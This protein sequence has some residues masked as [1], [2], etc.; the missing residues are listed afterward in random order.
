MKGLSVS[1]FISTRGGFCLCRVGLFQYTHIPTRQ[2]IPSFSLYNKIVNRRCMV[3]FEHLLFL[4]YLCRFCNF[5]LKSWE[6]KKL[7]VDR[8]LALESPIVALNRLAEV[9]WYIVTE[10][11]N[12]SAIRRVATYKRSMCLFFP[13]CTTVLNHFDAAN[14][15]GW[16]GLGCTS[17]CRDFPH[18]SLGLSW[19]GEFRK[20]IIIHGLLLILIVFL[21]SCLRL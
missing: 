14:T 6:P 19:L 10:F 13:S 16:H 11:S 15:S 5:Q 18:T 12:V 8:E 17:E 4:G 20:E 1:T 7:K 3:W 21:K 2:S 9:K